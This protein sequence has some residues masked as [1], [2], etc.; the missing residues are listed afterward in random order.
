MPLTSDANYGKI[1]HILSAVA[2]RSRG[3]FACKR[4][5]YRRRNG[6]AIRKKLI[7]NN[8][9]EAIIILLGNPFYTTDISV[10]LWIIN[11]NKNARIAV[12]AELT[13][14]LKQKE[15]SKQDLL[16]VFNELGYKIKL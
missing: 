2:K 4:C 6:L 12:Q 1:L 10:A 13:D 16:A 7:E 9:I 5:A 3:I 11:K 14:L 15:K 8:L